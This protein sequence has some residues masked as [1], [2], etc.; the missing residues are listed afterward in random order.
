[1]ARKALY[2]KLGD[3]AGK[4]VLH[5]VFANPASPNRLVA[6]VAQI[7]LGDY[8]GFALLTQ[9]LGAKDPASRRLAA[10]ALGDIGEHE[11]LPA[12]IAL[13]RDSDWTVRLAA[14]ASVIAIVGLD[15]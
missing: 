7:P 9:Q 2:A 1:M 3:D 13:A 5:E 4:I 15:P 8:A 12:L 11:S 14:A 6:A 10:R